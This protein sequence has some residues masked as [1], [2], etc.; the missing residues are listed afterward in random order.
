MV[1]SLEKTKHDWE[2]YTEP[3][4][5]GCLGSK[6]TCFWPRGKL[7]GG[8]SG[9][10]VMLYIR[11]NRRDYDHWEE[12]GNPTWGWSSVLEYF[13]KSEDNRVPHVAADTKHH[14]VGGPLKV[15]TFNSV[16]PIKMILAEAVFELGYKE[17]YDCNGDE[18]LGFLTAQGTVDKGTR[19]SSAKAFLSP[20]KDRPNLHVI[21]YAHVTEL[22]YR[23]DGSVGGVRFTVQDNVFEALSRKEVVLSAGSLNTPQILMLSGIGPK[24]Q[25]NKFNIKIRKELP[26]GHNLQDHLFIPYGIVFKKLTSTLDLSDIVDAAY[27][28]SS[29]RVGLFSHVSSTDFMG[30]VNTMNDSKYPDIQYHTIHFQ[31][32]QPELLQL[33]NLLGYTD[34]IT[35]SFLKANAEAEIVLLISTLLNP[36]SI[37][38]VELRSADPYESPIIHHNYLVEQDDVDTLIRSVRILRN[39]TNT[40]I[41]KAKNAEA[42]R[43]KINHCDKIEYDSN[44]YWECYARHM[45]VT[46]YHPVGTAK[47]GPESDLRSVVDSTLKV[48]GVKGLRVA[49]ASIMPKIVSGNTNA[50]TIMIGEKAASF[51]KDEWSN[52]KHTEL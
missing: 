48:K 41:L 34:E 47:M 31:K 21:K 45:S 2:Y 10:N 39:L 8:S 35:E 23:K 28:Y 36:K 26:V 9:I 25:L 40:K 30:F 50:P 33:L 7:L 22:T 27:Q 14:G 51:I 12:L 1:F 24:H 5:T 17:I 29:Y 19:C 42:I 6:K 32:Q 11:G 49:D 46:L 15:D 38:Q 44:A 16:L 20:A 18:N 4:K 37:G 43:I 3:S 13:K 52:M